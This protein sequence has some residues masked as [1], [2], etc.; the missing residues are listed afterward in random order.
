MNIVI[1][2][3][4]IT[5]L[6][7]ACR[8]RE[9]LPNADIHLLE[10][11]PEWGGLLAG[12]HFERLGLYFDKG[13]HIFQQTGVP[14]LDS[15]LMEAIPS[16]DRLV[17]SQSEGDVAGVV[18]EGNLQHHS[19]YPDIRAHL[20]YHD[21]TSDIRR[22]V[23]SV[24]TTLQITRSNSLA[25]ESTQRFG[26]AYSRQVICPLLA[27]VFGRDSSELAAFAMVL[28]GMTRVVLDDYDDWA[29][30]CKGLAY[31]SI[32]GVPNQHQ[33]P[34]AYQHG[35]LSYYSRQR[36]SSSLING[37][38]K[39][40]LNSNVTLNASAKITCIDVDRSCIEWIDFAGMSHRLAY[41]A[42]IFSAGAIAA[43]G[44][45]KASLHDYSFDQPLRHHLIHFH[46]EYPTKSSLCYFYSLDAQ[47]PWYR[48]TNYRAFSGV[49]EDRRLTIEVF[50][51][52]PP[53]SER[54]KETLRGL[55]QL[56]F[57]ETAD[58]ECVGI[59]TLPAGFPVP[60]IRNL[61][62]MIDLGDRLQSTLPENIVLGGI[63]SDRDS[64][65]QNE[66]VKAMYWKVSR[67]ADRLR[68][69]KACD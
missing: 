28:P 51:Q 31:R 33:L 34:T 45:L 65:F 19:H 14:G 8:M 41:T 36:G 49:S 59:E 47:F 52:V 3:G 4:G 58:G 22:H 30:R 54:A 37:L 69:L 53:T 9:L 23:A 61:K 18:F 11:S 27:N 13:T 17:F 50:G 10:R 56:G 48:V 29:S 68:Y 1:V 12:H 44:L 26:Q 60:T 67:L 24:N 7:A 57:C 16:N 5:G 35:R 66:V 6:V 15:M 38:R 62:A 25:S 21:V 39:H 20:K 55:F 46:L 64:F 43:A 2:G 32:I 40:L 63:G 42:M